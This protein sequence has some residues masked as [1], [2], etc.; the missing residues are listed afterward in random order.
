MICRHLL[1]ES[2]RQRGSILIISLIMLV[3]LTLLAVSSINM[4]TMSLRTVNS[5]QA[6]GEAMSAAQRAID[7]IINAN[8]VDTIGTV[9]GTY[10]V[11]IDAGKSYD[12]VVG[13][14]CLK[15]SLA[16]YNTQLDVTSAEDLKCYDTTTNPLSACANTV[17]QIT[18]SVNEGFFGANI[19]L[20]QGIA[21]RMDNGSAIAYSVSTAPVYTCP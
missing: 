5:M 17:W 8:F 19:S 16:I 18:A 20:V 1:P 11:P 7:Q 9:A 15:Q 2:A 13:T 14:P 6:R 3:V 12:V 21:L 4:S 10:T